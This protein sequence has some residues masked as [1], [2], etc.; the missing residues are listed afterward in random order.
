MTSASQSP[1]NTGV[2]RIQRGLHAHLRLF[3]DYVPTAWQSA[4]DGYRALDA[5]DLALLGPGGG[6]ASGFQLYDAP[7]A[8]TWGDWRRRRAD[9]ARMLPQASW[10]AGDVVFCPDLLWDGR[11]AFYRRLPGGVL[12]VGVFHD[13]IGLRRGWRA[14]VDGWLCA[15]GIR[16]LADFDLVLCISREA[17]VDLRAAWAT[18]GLR[19]ART[20]VLPWPVPFEGP[21]PET[22]GRFSAREL[23]YV[24]RLEEHKNH[25]RLLEACEMLWRRGLEFRLRLVGCNAY[26]WHSW[27]VRRRIAALR[28]RGCRIDLRAHVAEP[29]LHAAYRDCSFTVFPSLLEGFGLPILESLWHRRP[30]VCGASGAV[31]EVAAAGGCEPCDPAEAASL[32]AAMEHLLTRESHYRALCRQAAE[33]VFTRWPDYW[34]AV[35]VEIAALRAGGAGR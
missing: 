5:A 9:A 24:A 12:R 10:R 2:K 29:E 23:L 18:A 6:A 7:F 16:A 14:G 21:R 1:L 20:R 35:E 26:P 32:A 17:E 33:R 34:R 28:R 25:P 22:E 8:G 31:G 19:P 27:R 4:L 13:A 11:G 15:R 30:V 3:P